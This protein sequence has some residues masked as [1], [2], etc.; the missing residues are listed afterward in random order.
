MF[1]VLKRDNRAGQY[2]DAG[3]S[4]AG[5]LEL[6]FIA[7]TFELTDYLYH[8]GKVW[9]G[10]PLGVG[11]LCFWSHNYFGGESILGEYTWILMAAIASAGVGIL[12][13]L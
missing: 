2:S 4:E 9:S 1:C 13:A 8:L 5:D 6:C 10:T 3:S 12:F 7:T 11:Y